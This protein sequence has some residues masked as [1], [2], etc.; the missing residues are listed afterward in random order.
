MVFNRLCIAATIVVKSPHHALRVGGLP[1]FPDNTIKMMF[2]TDLGVGADGLPSG[3]PG[4]DGRNFDVSGVMEYTLAV[5]EPSTA[6][7]AISAVAGCM[8]RRRSIG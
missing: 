8:L 2:W 4:D 1:I 3:F 6:A 5:P 7:L